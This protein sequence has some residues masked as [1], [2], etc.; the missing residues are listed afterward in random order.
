MRSPS[1]GMI[2]VISVILA[3]GITYARL[4]DRIFSFRQKNFEQFDVSS[5]N[6]VGQASN[7]SPEKKIE[8]GMALPTPAQFEPIR[9]VPRPT[10][11][12]GSAQSP[13]LLTPSPAVQQNTNAAFS[14]FS[15]FKV[16]EELK[17]LREEMVQGGIIKSNEFVIINN[18]PDMEKFLLKVVEWK[19]KQT[20]AA[21]DEIEKAKNKIIAGYEELRTLPY[22]K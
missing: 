8:D 19:A 22:R 20:G 10:D 5:S 16:S 1:T 17:I 18:Y 2:I 21:A 6:S 12:L 15:V 13:I 9:D 11:N 4:P 7:S 14:G 3:G